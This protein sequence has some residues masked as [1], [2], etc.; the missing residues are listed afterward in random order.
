MCN[1]DSTEHAEFSVGLR[2]QGLPRINLASLLFNAIDSGTG[3]LDSLLGAAG[4]FITTAIEEGLDDLAVLNSDIPDERLFPLL[5]GGNSAEFIDPSS[6]VGAMRNVHQDLVG[7]ADANGVVSAGTIADVV[8]LRVTG[9]VFAGGPTTG[10]T[11][12][13]A[14][15]LTQLVRPS[16]GN[17][18]NSLTEAVDDRLAR[19]QNAIRAFGDR[20]LIGKYS[21]QDI[22]VND[23]EHTI[24]R[25]DEILAIVE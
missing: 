24:L 22:K 8:S 19:F 16:G 6:A 15:A 1:P 18:F 9:K 14:N 21:G 10:E 17:P 11:V 12:N 4:E 20:I 25:E 5:Y 2:Y 13:V 3:A 7:E 23:V